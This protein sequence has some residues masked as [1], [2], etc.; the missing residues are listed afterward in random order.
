MDATRLPIAV[1]ELTLKPCGVVAHAYCGHLDRNWEPG[2]PPAGQVRVGFAF[3]PARDDSRPALGTYV[4]HEGGP[5]Y[6]T[7]GTGW[8]YAA[9]YGPLLKRH[10]L[11]L[12]D[13]RG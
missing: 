1:G 8:S 6:S 12:V 4:P 13:Q 10:N 9:M 5:G 2:N 7:T 3:L 11:L